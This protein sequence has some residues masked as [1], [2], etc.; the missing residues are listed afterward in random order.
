MARFQSKQHIAD[1]AASEM[2]AHRAAEGFRGRG[3][4]GLGFLRRRQRK[5]DAEDKIN[6]MTV[7]ELQNELRS[8]QKEL[9]QAVK[10][11]KDQAERVH[12]SEAELEGGLHEAEGAAQYMDKFLKDSA[13]DVEMAAHQRVWL[14]AVEGFVRDAFGLP[15]LSPEEARDNRLRGIKEKVSDVDPLGL[16]ACLTRRLGMAA[17]DFDRAAHSAVV[18]FHPT[19]RGVLKVFEADEG[20]ELHTGE[21]IR[22]TDH[23]PLAADVWKVMHSGEPVLRN[24][25]GRA[26]VAENVRSVFPLHESDGRTFGAVVSGP[27]ALPDALLERFMRVAGELFERAWKMY[28]VQEALSS[29]KALMLQMAREQQKL[30]YV[31][32]APGRTLQYKRVEMQSQWTWQPLMFTPPDNANKFEVELRFKRNTLG[33]SKELPIGVWSI[34]L[35]GL[36]HMDERLITT[37]HTLGPMMQKCVEDIERSH[38]GDP[39]P[40]ATMADAQAEFNH[41]HMLLPSKLQAEVRQQLAHLHADAVFAELL[42][43]KEADPFVTKIMRSILVLLGHPRKELKTWEQIRPLCTT[44]LLSEMLSLDLLAD[45][46]KMRKRWAESMRVTEAAH[47]DEAS[48]CGTV[49]EPV[50]LLFKWLE[51]TRMVHH[52]ALMAHEDMAAEHEAAT[53]NEEAAAEQ[54]AQARADGHHKAKPSASKKRNKAARASAPRY[55][56]P[57]IAKVV[58]HAK[59]SNPDDHA[60][61]GID[62][63]DPAFED[64][65]RQQKQKR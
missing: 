24:P 19:A 11:T 44:E 51:T 16:A 29:A 48:V 61:H 15:D 60:D 56:D 10:S 52:V 14:L 8:E 1:M 3:I 63:T 31:M 65:M 12:A 30:V 7:A 28:M 6:H 35:G 37:I 2:D 22:A 50:H 40:F 57:T 59:A 49:S 26:D 5:R 64:L 33:K 25:H 53:K 9:R 58:K 38:V 20:S 43:Y 32:W 27:P 45:T 23:S 39:A 18:L 47:I 21:I 42:S 17:D 36:S 62:T 34:D 54:H 4:W 55:T 46:A 13:G 41:V